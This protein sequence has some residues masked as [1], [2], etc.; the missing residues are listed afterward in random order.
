MRM[1]HSVVIQRPPSEVFAYLTDVERLPEW[2]ASAN[3]V[4]PEGELGLG[5]RIHEVRT[6]L[7]RRAES[8]LEVIEFEPDRKFS[9]RVVS[10]PLPF[11]VR[12]TLTPENAGTRLD[13]VGEADTS[14]F[15]GIAVR[16]VAGAVEGQFKADFE[17]LKRLLE[18]PTESPSP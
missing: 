3:E 15:P 8:T 18:A 4:R 17:R 5:T 1:E 14:R 10:G 13:W 7:G 6:F 16:M 12:H 11:E 2:Q 9:L